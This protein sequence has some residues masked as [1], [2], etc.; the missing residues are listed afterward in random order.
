MFSFLFV[1]Y[2]GKELL[3]HMVTLFEELTSCYPMWC[4]YF[5]FPPAIMK[6]TISP[7]PYQ[8]LLSL[9]IAVIL[10]GVKK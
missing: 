8:N 7:R 10:M 4:Y 5:A 1:K 2:L 9:L 3:A 6:V